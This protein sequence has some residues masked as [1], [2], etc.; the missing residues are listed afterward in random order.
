[1]LPPVRVGTGSREADAAMI[2]KRLA[3]RTRAQHDATPGKLI[4]ANTKFHNTGVDHI[5]RSVQN[6]VSLC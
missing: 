2:L 4:S 6:E 1:M 5:N 3:P